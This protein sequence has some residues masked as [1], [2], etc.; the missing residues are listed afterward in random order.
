MKTKLFVV[1]V[2]VVSALAYAAP[3]LALFLD[4]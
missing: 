3:A 4:K 1:A 2:L